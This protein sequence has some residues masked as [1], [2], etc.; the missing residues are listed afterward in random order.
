MSQK[1][2]VLTINVR[3]IR[4]ENLDQTHQAQ[5][6]GLWRDIKLCFLKRRRILFSK[7]ASFILCYFQKLGY[8]FLI[9]VFTILDNLT[10]LYRLAVSGSKHSLKHIYLSPQK[11][12]HVKTSAHHMSDL[13]KT[14]QYTTFGKLGGSVFFLQLIQ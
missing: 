2:A 6:F 14:C 5:D 1:S 12:F 4:Q 3:E 8:F 11:G 7:S 9:I 13:T 10:H